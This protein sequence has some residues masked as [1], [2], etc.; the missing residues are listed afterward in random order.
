MKKIVD[1]LISV[2]G[3]SFDRMKSFSLFLC[4]LL[5]AFNG[6]AQ[7][8]DTWTQKADLGGPGRYAAVAFSIGTKGYIGTG[9]RYEG[10]MKDFWEYDPNTDAW[11][12]KA[13]FGGTARWF[14]VGFSVHNKGYIGTGHDETGYNNDFW[15]YS[16]VSNSW[17]RKADFGGGARDLA[18]GFSI[19]S[20][21]YIGTGYDGAV[22]KDFWE[23]NPYSNSWTQKADFGG[24]GR[25][26]AS[27]FAIKDKGYIGTGFDGS[28]YKKDFW[29]FNPDSNEWSQKADF[30]GIER[31]IPAGFSIGNKGYFGTGYGNGYHNDFWEYSQNLDSWT[32][33][34]NFGGA[35]RT[36]AL[37]F[38]IGSKGY[39]G[40]GYID[41]VPQKDFWQY[42]AGIQVSAGPD[43]TVYDGYPPA[44][45]ALLIGSATGG[46]APYHYAWSNGAL[47]AA[48]VVCPSA[49]TIYTLTVTDANGYSNTDQVTVTVI[50]VRCGNNKVIICHGSRTICVS[51]HAVFAHLIHG[52]HLGACTN[53]TDKSLKMDAPD[54]SGRDSFVLY[55]NPTTGSFTVESCKDNVAEG[56]KIQIVNTLG[57]VI[58]SKIPL[59]NGGCIRETIDLN[60]PQGMYYIN[61]TVGENVETRK[62]ILTK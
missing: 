55:P 61:L 28:N 32:Q 33:K 31:E 46:T 11:T 14:A 41:G 18:A 43:K 21:G 7:V 12:Q 62:L 15:E 56:A 53:C 19:N 50:D 8:P 47:T 25:Q 27:G 13:D 36:E 59:I 4:L 35:A 24:L 60:H 44:Q 40:T 22:K 58:Y 17:T 48:T 34:A 26:G 23:Y 1:F 54:L 6:F 3:N 42:D 51:T 10:F 49:T 2:I 38:S 39:I 16:P 57:Q 52:D 9:F 30:G 37:G 29:E 5:A 45:C 20:K